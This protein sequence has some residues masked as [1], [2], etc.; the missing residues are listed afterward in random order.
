MRPRSRSAEMLPVVLKF[1]KEPAK[2]SVGER[3]L[4]MQEV[5]VHYKVHPLFLVSRLM[6]QYPVSHLVS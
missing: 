5:N 6:P 4:L 3:D 1:N 2:W